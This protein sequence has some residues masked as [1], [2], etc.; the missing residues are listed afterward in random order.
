MYK[1][2][3]GMKT[4]CIS[5]VY[6]PSLPLLRSRHKNVPPPPYMPWDDPPMMLRVHN[7][8]LLLMS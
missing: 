2:K 4:H 8:L 3:A 6:D 5:R 7:K 1:D